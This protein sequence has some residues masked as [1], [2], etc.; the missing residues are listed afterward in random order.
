VH[1][2]D[3]APGVLLIGFYLSRG[4]AGKR[5]GAVMA[6]PNAPIAFEPAILTWCSEADLAAD[7]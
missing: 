2:P 1:R 5:L 7:D 3:G 6:R 4:L